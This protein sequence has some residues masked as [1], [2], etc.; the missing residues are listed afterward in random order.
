[1]T[2]AQM[3]NGARF[4][5]RPLTVDGTPTQDW[6]DALVQAP[7]WDVSNCREIV[8]VAAHPD[9]E[10]LGFGGTLATLAARG[11]RVQVVAASDG[12][13]SHP[14]LER[15]R[16]ERIRCAELHTA[17]RTLR[18]PAPICLG[19]PDGE[20]SDHEEWLAERLTS[21]LEGRPVWIAATWR[22]D[23]HPDHEAVGRAA[24]TA[25]QRCGAVFVEYPIWMWHWATPGDPVVPWDRLR[26][27]PVTAHALDRKTAATRCYRSQ[28]Q[29]IDSP[30]LL[31]PFVVRRLLD[32]PEVVF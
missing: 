11:V 13:A 27:A 6:L 24:A 5:A 15:R 7:A 25:A 12:G 28:L 10:T 9:D 2:L 32:V 17:A 22:G 16:L 8:V 21:L 18:V 26:I 1:M 3:G 30:P 20:L 19:L 4:V 14:H 29:S 23:G 31:P